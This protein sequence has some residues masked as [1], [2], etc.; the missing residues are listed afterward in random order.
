MAY[1]KQTWSNYPNTSSPI[2]A[3][4]LNHM[5]Q[6]IEDASES[7]IDDTQSSLNKTYSSNKIESLI[8]DE[9]TYD[10]TN[11]S[12]GGNSIDLYYSTNQGQTYSKYAFSNS[13]Y[14]FVYVSINAEISKKILTKLSV[15]LIDG[16]SLENVQV[17]KDSNILGPGDTITNYDYY[18]CPVDSN[19]YIGIII[20]RGN[21]GSSSVTWYFTILRMDTKKYDAYGLCN[22]SNLIISIMNLVFKENSAADII[23][24][25]TASRDSTYSSVK[26]LEVI[27]DKVSDVIDDSQPGEDS[28]YSSDKINEL[29]VG[30]NIEITYDYPTFDS[31]SDKTIFYYTLDGGQTYQAYTHGNTPY[32]NLWYDM[33][34]AYDNVIS[35]EGNKAYIKADSTILC[36]DEI[37]SKNTDYAS[38]NTAYTVFS[39]PISGE[40]NKYIAFAFDNQ[41]SENCYIALLD[42]SNHTY[43][44]K[45]LDYKVVS[46]SKLSFRGSPSF[47]DDSTASGEKTYSSIKIEELI[48]NLQSQINALS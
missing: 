32:L 16:T 14:P 44:A 3:E 48:A 10:A 21:G 39:A 11:F 24:D 9:E 25:N 17:E 5:E 36:N 4:R 28:T 33:N 29:C 42:T 2:N 26:I 23:N 37:L 8:S 27:T 41:A 22:T 34:F 12:R 20:N 40:S 18:I 46:N 15:D 43:S 35:K 7:E 45:A 30:S 13:C 19:R 38:G 47:I 6:G 1:E 31:A